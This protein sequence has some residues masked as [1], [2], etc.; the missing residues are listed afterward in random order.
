MGPN[1]NVPRCRD[2][3][4]GG[5]CCSR[6]K[7]QE[8][9]KLSQERSKSASEYAGS[10]ALGGGKKLLREGKLADEPQKTREAAQRGSE[11]KDCPGSNRKGAPWGLKK[12]PEGKN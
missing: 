10:V 7:P 11:K 8:E 5:G 6:P 12:M 1:S 9:K 2:W 3:G 4:G